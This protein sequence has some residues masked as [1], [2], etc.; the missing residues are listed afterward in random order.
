VEY[1]PESFG[2]LCR[3]FL[4]R[5]VGLIRYLTRRLPLAVTDCEREN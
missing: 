2:V 3:L 5:R 1:E 4:L